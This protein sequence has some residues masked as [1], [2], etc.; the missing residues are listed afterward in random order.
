MP[1]PSQRPPRSRGLFLTLTATAALAVLS[2]CGASKDGKGGREAGTPEVGYRVMQPT[3]APIVVELPGRIAASRSAEV[4]P[5]ITGI[6]QAR[7][8]TEG[9]LVRAGQPLYRIDSSL[10]RASAAQAQA[11]L[12]SAEA[13]AAAASAKA[14]RYKPLAEA[15]AVASQDYTDAVAAA[16]QARAAVAQTRAALN[17]AQI[18]LRFTTVPAPITG[19]IGRS[20]L[21][22]GA[23]A[24]S[25]QG[26]PLA[27]ISVLDP[28]YVDLQ[29]SAGDL[30]KLRA[31]LAQNGQ[32]PASATVWLYLDDGT[33]YPVA[34]NLAF[35]EVTANPA[36]GTVA[37]R[38]RFANPQ[39]LL[40]PGM[41]VRARLEQGSQ[42]NVFLVPQSAMSRDPRGNAQV[43]VLGKD[44]KAEAR[45]VTALRTEGNDWVVSAGLK[46]GDKLITQGLGKA[47]AGRPVKAVPEGTSQQPRSGKPKSG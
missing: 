31:Q 20:L 37:L 39:G 12:A 35:S 45:P 11:N 33:K 44:G 36:T 30:M 28:V 25:G 23:L 6:I 3:S 16:R 46:P 38:A 14:A 18:T 24:T 19:R 47:R 42:Q 40:L 27:V 4:R 7:L 21:T 32:T 34:G 10:Y 8:F 17:T 5:Q 43:L 41:F 22:E 2:G 9:S 29:Q 1:L 13:S 15:G 26:D